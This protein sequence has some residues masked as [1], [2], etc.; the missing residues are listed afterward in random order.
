MAIFKENTCFS[1]FNA[2]S[3][4]RKENEGQTLKTDELEKLFQHQGG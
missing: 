2:V 1:V 4:T 3:T